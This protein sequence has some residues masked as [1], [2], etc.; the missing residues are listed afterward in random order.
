[1]LR[2]VAAVS[3][4]ALSKVPLG[5]SVT[6]GKK[7]LEAEKTLTDLVDIGM[8]TPSLAHDVLDQLLAIA[9]KQAIVPVFIALD[10]VNTLWSNTF[11]R[12]QEDVILP[13]NRLRLVRSF[14]PFFEGEAALAKG[15]VVGA[16][17]YMEGRFMP[18]SLKAMLNPP[19]LV[20]LANPELSYDPKV[21]NPSAS[22][23]FDVV[24][25][26]RLSSAEAWAMMSFYQKANVVTTPL[27]EGLVAKKWVYANGN[28][29]QMFAGVTTYF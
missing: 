1:L 3:R 13:A 10:S 22:L 2:S 19:P 4:E 17:S 9:S 25:V 5:T 20:P 29:R 14:L 7:T 27:T 23:P 28:P 12:D 6:L 26:N 21:A 18:K 15:W 11:Y 8:Q 16:T 24:K